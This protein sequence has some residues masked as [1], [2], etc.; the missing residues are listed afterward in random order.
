MTD[1]DAVDALLA[2]V[3]PEAELPAPGERIR[4]RESA[5]LTKAQ[6]ARAL[7]VS[8]TTL[9]GWEAGR[10]PSG[11]T[12]T[13]Y[14]YLLDGLRARLD[15]PAAPAPAPPAP[16]RDPAPAGGPA[17]VRAPAADDGDLVRA[18]AADDGDLVRAPAADDGERLAEPRPCVLCGHPAHHEV[19]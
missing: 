12:R 15:T 16:D 6:V 1:F 7:G 17:P 2:A 11:E 5:R 14:A 8:P 13:R 4:L 18:P 9:A 3:A 19:A 10:E